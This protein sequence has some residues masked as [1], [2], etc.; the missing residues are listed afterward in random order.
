M[1][2]LERARETLPEIEEEWIQ[3]IKSLEKLNR[4]VDFSIALYRQFLNYFEIEKS[5]LFFRTEENPEGLKCL[6]SM[7][8]DKTTS[9]RLRL[10]E[11]AM[12]SDFFHSL[13]TEKR[14][15]L[16]HSCDLSFFSDYF[17][18]REF[19][20]MEDLF[21]LP[22]IYGDGVVSLIMVSQWKSFPPD[23]WESRFAEISRRFSDYIYLSRKALSAQKPASVQK[24]SD[25]S[26]RLFIME[27]SNPD[28]H[29]FAIDLSQ[30][31][32]KLL[33]DNGGMNR[34]N[35]K[36][37]IISV[38][39]TMAGP[40]QGVLDLENQKVLFMLDKARIADKALFLHQLS[41]S[42]PLL[43]Q[44]LSHPPELMTADFRIPESDEDWAEL[45][46]TLL[47]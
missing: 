33:T 2:L 42:L 15:L 14:S 35:L 20:L 25:E 36:K 45:S 30:L 11:R 41:A 39:R 18:S 26:L 44:D 12:D 24:I 46:E 16:S 10:D 7:G 3:F 37:E 6:S 21:W 34:L 1:G 17:S 4:G 9:N 27:R 29:L 19:G 32:D 5:A 40:S 8:Y 38:F 22:F 23:N 13:N 43:F 47:R 31:I 28:V